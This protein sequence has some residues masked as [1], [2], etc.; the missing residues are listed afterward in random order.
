LGGSAQHPFA[1]LTIPGVDQA[2][3]NAGELH[4]L[5]H[6]TFVVI[7]VNVSGHLQDWG[8]ALMAKIAPRL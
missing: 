2:A 5:A 3:E 4:A 1:A 8:P 7:I 6:D